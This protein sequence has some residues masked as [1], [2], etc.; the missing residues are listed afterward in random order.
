MYS[1]K[2]QDDQDSC[3]ILSSEREDKVLKAFAHEMS[4]FNKPSII[5][6]LNSKHGDIHEI[7][8]YVLQIVFPI[9]ALDENS[10]FDKNVGNL[11]FYLDSKQCRH[12]DPNWDTS[13]ELF[14]SF[15]KVC[16]FPDYDIYDDETIIFH[17]CNKTTLKKVFNENNIIPKL[18]QLLLQNLN[19]DEITSNRARNLLLDITPMRIARIR[20]ALGGV[21]CAETLSYNARVLQ[22]KLIKPYL[23]SPDKIYETLLAKVKIP[24]FSRW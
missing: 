11:Y 22:L 10:S 16:S 3:R 21:G 19:L 2:K 1:D 12:Y 14:R 15:Y 23:W 13:N 6:M 5:R 17:T 7:L 8:A 24:N 20:N 9:N 4:E 18:I